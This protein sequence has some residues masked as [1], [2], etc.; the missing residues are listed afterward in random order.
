MINEWQSR[1]SGAGR[2]ANEIKRPAH[3]EE[4]SLEVIWIFLPLFVYLF[5]IGQAHKTESGHLSSLSD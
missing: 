2:N 3:Y 4:I 5:Y 1:L